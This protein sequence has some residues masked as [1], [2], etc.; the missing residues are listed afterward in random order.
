MF[1]V[2]GIFPGTSASGLFVWGAVRLGSV[3]EPVGGAPR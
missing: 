2:P 3:R 1:A